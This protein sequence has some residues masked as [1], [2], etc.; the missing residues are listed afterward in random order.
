MRS[1][2]AFGTLFD[3]FVNGENPLDAIKNNLG[4]V[5]IAAI[6]APFIIALIGKLAIPALAATVIKFIATSIFFGIGKSLFNRFRIFGGKDKQVQQPDTEEVQLVKPSSETV[7]FGGQNVS[8]TDTLVAQT[9]NNA[10]NIVPVN[11]KK[12][13]NVVDNISNFE[14]GGTTIVNIPTGESDQTQSTQLASAGGPEEPTSKLPFIGFD[15]DNIHTQYAITTY[16]AF[17]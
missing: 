14:E 7:S 13:M 12:E 6:S 5:L 3:I 1:T 4:G 10:D 2:L 8:D 15:N 16:G 11:N 9:T 17:A